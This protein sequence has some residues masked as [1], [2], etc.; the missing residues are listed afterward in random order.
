MLVQICSRL[1]V[2]VFSMCS[3]TSGYGFILAVSASIPA[4]YEYGVIMLDTIMPE[5]HSLELPLN[6][7]LFCG[8]PIRLHFQSHF[9]CSMA[10]HDITAH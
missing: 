4:A 3:C 5:G 10:Y 8:N 2:L 6:V 9:M 1:L 7:R